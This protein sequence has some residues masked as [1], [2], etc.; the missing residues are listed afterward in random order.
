VTRTRLAHLDPTRQPRFSPRRT[1][2]TATGRNRREPSL[3][4]SR[5]PLLSTIGPIPRLLKDLPAR[6]AIHRNNH[7]RATT[8]TRKP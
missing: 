2:R 4:L 1:T 8:A 6:R 3:S 7:Q 5:H